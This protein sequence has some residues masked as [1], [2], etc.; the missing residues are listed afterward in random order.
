MAIQSA[1]EIV[2]R[3]K[4]LSKKIEDAEFKM[5]VA[6]LS[7]ALAD[8]KLEVANLKIELAKAK[9]M[10][11]EKT[12]LFERQATDRPTLSEGAYQFADDTGFFVRRATTQES[13][14]Y[15]LRRCRMDLTIWGSGSAPLAAPCLAPGRSA[16]AEQ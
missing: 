6:D 3:L 11:Q 9:E 16:N 8:A 4:N 13:N 5:L 14:E 12:T 10:L 7:G 1:I 15:E 2:S